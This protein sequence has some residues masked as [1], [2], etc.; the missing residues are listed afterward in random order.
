MLHE[1]HHNQIWLAFQETKRRGKIETSRVSGVLSHVYH[2][3][4]MILINY[5]RELPEIFAHKQGE[6]FLFCGIIEDGQVKLC[7]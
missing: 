3:D 5:S 7:L 2:D 4:T 6:G 1:S